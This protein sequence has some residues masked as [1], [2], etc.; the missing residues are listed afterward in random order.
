MARVNAGKIS[1]PTVG[2]VPGA[3]WRVIDD[4]R[5]LATAADRPGYTADPQLV[6]AFQRDGVVVVP[7][8][9]ADWVEPLRA[10]LQRN[11]DHPDDYAF[12]CDSTGADEPGRFFD[13]YCN[14]QRVGEYL[15]FVLSS[16][17]AAMAAAF[18][19]STTAQFFHD[20]AFSKESGT[21]K[22]TPW[23]HD[24]PYYCVE[25]SQT[26]SIYVSLDD[27]G[28][29]TV[30]RFAKG[31]HRTGHLYYPRA[32]SSGAE[33]TSD[34]QNLRSVPTAAELRDDH[35]ILAVPLEPG[36]AVV[37]DF[38]TLHGTTDAP[39]TTRRRAFSTRW[40]GDDAVYCER[41]GETSPPL[42]DLNVE[43]G[44]RLRTD[45]FP[46]LWPPTP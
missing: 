40:L 10:G 24:L 27:V 33:Y 23:H 4:V 25:G 37:F 13:S 3:Q 18:M 45:W 29:D 5:P 30:V 7:G 31:T 34:D 20:H 2:N 16:S 17:A 35:D 42:V 46:I 15:A 43:P 14:W 9:F 11:L 39:I 36:D 22:A 6:E 44:E 26:A 28:E 21:Q 1:T 32:F 8:A 19:G 38:R 12:P 41:P